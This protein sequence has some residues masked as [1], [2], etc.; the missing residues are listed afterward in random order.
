VLQNRGN[1]GLD[2]FIAHSVQRANA[3]QRPLV[4]ETLG[5]YEGIYSAT[6]HIT[7]FEEMSCGL[8]HL[9]VGRKNLDETIPRTQLSSNGKDCDRKVLYIRAA[10]EG[11]DVGS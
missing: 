3:I 7:Y 11:F 5:E 4:Q 1:G 2:H 10:V 9:Q 6:P 8:C